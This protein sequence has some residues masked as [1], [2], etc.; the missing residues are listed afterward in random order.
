MDPPSV[1]PPQVEQNY[2]AFKAKH[3][4]PPIDDWLRRM[5]PKN[6]FKLSTYFPTLEKM[7][8]RGETAYNNEDWRR[9][10]Q[11]SMKVATFILECK[12]IHNGWRLKVN[13]KETYRMIRVVL[14]KCISY[15]IY[16]TVSATAIH[17]AV[18]IFVFACVA[19]IVSNT[20]TTLFVSLFD[21]L[22][23]PNLL[24][25][26]MRPLPMDQW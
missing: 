15:A 3:L 2:Q 8:D 16:N 10:Y 26:P 18:R 7:F 12:K 1:F 5:K 19:T 14:P 9:A 21:N 24:R 23:Q 22:I 13:Q 17:Y 6:K 11:D 4:K 20:P 25:F